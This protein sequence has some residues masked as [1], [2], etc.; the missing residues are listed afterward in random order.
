MKNKYKL[1]EY[2]KILFIVNLIPIFVFCFNFNYKEKII[3]FGQILQTWLNYPYKFIYIIVSFLSFFYIF[4][5]QRQKEKLFTSNIL[6]EEFNYILTINYLLIFFNLLID[7]KY[8]TCFFNFILDYFEKLNPDIQNYQKVIIY[9]IFEF[10]SLLITNFSYF[11]LLWNYFTKISNLSNFVDNV[12]IKINKNIKY[13][14]NL[15]IKNVTSLLLFL[16]I[17]LVMLFWFLITN[18][19]VIIYFLLITTI[20]III[21]KNQNISLYLLTKPKNIKYAIK[22]TIFIG[23]TLI[24]LNFISIFTAYHILNDIWANFYHLLEVI[25]FFLINV[26]YFVNVKNLLK[27]IKLSLVDQN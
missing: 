9:K 17:Y 14:Q 10:T 4:Y 1:K 2:L 11:I 8:F 5:L 18:N 6:K 26:F 19:I 23:N 12:P 25:I 20:F 24:F 3:G 15:L 16:K 13:F 7:F 27:K 22:S 21:F